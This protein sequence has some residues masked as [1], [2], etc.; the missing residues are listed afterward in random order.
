MGVINQ[1]LTKL[2]KTQSS[3]HDPFSHAQSLLRNEEDIPFEKKYYGKIVGMRAMLANISNDYLLT[4]IQNDVAILTAAYEIACREPEF[5]PV[6]EYMYH[7]WIGGLSMTRA[8]QGKERSLQSTPGGGYMPQQDFGGYGEDLNYLPDD[9]SQQGGLLDN[10][11]RLPQ[12]KTRRPNYK[13]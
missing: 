12:V 7:S 4:Y 6:F 9:P 11:P 2:Q 3:V 10:M 13:M 1:V 8:N 5:I